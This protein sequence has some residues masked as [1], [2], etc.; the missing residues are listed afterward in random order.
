MFLESYIPKSF[1]REYIEIKGHSV[2]LGMFMAVVLGLKPLM[3]DWIPLAKLSAFKKVCSKYGLYV[4][5]DVIFKCLPKEDIPD[6]V[7]GKENL[8][9][10]T[11]FGYPLGSRADGEM[12][13]FVVKDKAFLSQAM[14]YPVIIKNRVIFQPRIDSLKYGYVLG[15]PDCCIKF[16]RKYNNWFEYSYLYEAYRNTKAKPSFLCNPFL[17][18]S[19]FSY[20]YHMPCSYSCEATKKLAGKLRDEIARHEPEYVRRADKC[21]KMP[22]L[23]FYERKLYCFDGVL[24]G[25]RIKYTKFYFPSHDRS[26]DFYSGYF[27]KANEVRLEGRNLLFFKDGRPTAKVEVKKNPFAPD[28]PFFIDFS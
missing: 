26:K 28:Q 14:W 22:F 20:I 13:L 17:K 11:A 25:N 18:D 19:P 24:E 4:K 1:C 23:V 5:E 21:L 3:D 2:Q 7:I 16:F 12:H 15:Y 9:T 27:K 6:K 10:T 8:T